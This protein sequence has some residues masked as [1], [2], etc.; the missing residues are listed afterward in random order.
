MGAEKPIRPSRGS[1]STRSQMRAAALCYERIHSA[2]ARRGERQLAAVWCGC[3]HDAHPGE[4]HLQ[5][6]EVG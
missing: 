3:A 2:A 6:S 5:L 1:V 4:M